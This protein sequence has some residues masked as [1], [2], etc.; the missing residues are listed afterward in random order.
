MKKTNYVGSKVLIETGTRVHREGKPAVQKRSSKVT[1]SKQ[2]IT[3]K[4]KTRIVWMSQ[5]YRAST[6][7][8]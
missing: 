3:T 2:E 8:D 1:V 4:G 7:I 6:I 5:G